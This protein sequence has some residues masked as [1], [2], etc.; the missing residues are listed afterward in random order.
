MNYDDAKGRILADTFSRVDV[1]IQMPVKQTA[2]F[3]SSGNE[4]F[5]IGNQHRDADFNPSPFKLQSRHITYADV[6]M[7]S[8]APQ[9]RSLG[10]GDKCRPEEEDPSDT[11][12][13]LICSFDP[14]SSPTD[15]KK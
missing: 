12:E 4:V 11:R 13:W 2:S 15:F 8:H 1:V 3:Q 14:L 7:P 9:I 6:P 10:M 5:Q